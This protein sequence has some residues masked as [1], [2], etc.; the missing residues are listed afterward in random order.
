M[1]AGHGGAALVACGE[2]RL[3]DAPNFAIHLV[4]GDSLLHGRRFGEL[5]LDGEAENLARAALAHVY[6]VEDLGDQPY[7]RSTAPCGGQQPA[8]WSRTRR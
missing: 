5:G 8:L 1:A 6:R 3:D 7:P 4:A 2:G